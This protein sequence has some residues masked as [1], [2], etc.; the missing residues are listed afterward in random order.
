MANP[1]KPKPILDILLRNREKLVE[2]LSKFQLAN[3]ADSNLAEQFN[4]EKAYVIKQI[5]ELKSIPLPV[6]GAGGGGGGGLN[7][8]PPLPPPNPAVDQNG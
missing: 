4:D 8:G 5:R 2:F 7:Q 3:E 6:S 1:H